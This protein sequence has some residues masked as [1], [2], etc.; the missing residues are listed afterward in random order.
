MSSEQVDA[1]K[2]AEGAPAQSLPSRPA[3]EKKE[4]KAGGGKASLEVCWTRFDSTRQLPVFAKTIRADIDVVIVASGSPRIHSTPYRH[5]R[6]DQ[7]QARRRGCWFVFAQ[8][9]LLCTVGGANE[10]VSLQPS[11]ARKSPFPCPMARRRRVPLG[12]PLLEPLPGAFRSP[13]S[14][15]PSSPWLMASFGILHDPLRRAASLS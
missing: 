7:G 9:S 8:D 2:A 10:C 6:Q 1:P 11:L 15:A 12:R 14:S 13:C 5:F 4:K 3:K